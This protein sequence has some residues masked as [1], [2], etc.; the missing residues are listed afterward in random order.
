MIVR[1]QM[2][3]V[4]MANDR[5][6][7]RILVFV[8]PK[9]FEQSLNVFFESRL[10]SSNHLEMCNERAIRKSVLCVDLA[11]LYERIFN[12]DLVLC[13]RFSRLR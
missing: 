4:L 12:G 8:R 6:S 13:K 5:E 2:C 9:S 3:L 11:F 10:Y 7:E 1:E